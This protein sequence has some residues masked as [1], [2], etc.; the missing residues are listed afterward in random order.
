MKGTRICG[1]LFLILFG[2]WILPVGCSGGGGSTP[3]TTPTTVPTPTTVQ[4]AQQVQNPVA[5]FTSTGDNNGVIIEFP[6][7]T[8]PTA[9]LTGYMVFGI[10]TEGNNSSN[11]TTK[12]Y[13]DTSGL[14]YTNFPSTSTTNIPSFIDSGSNG[15]F[16]PDTIYQCSSASVAPGFYCTS[17]N[18]NGSG[19]ALTSLTATIT[20]KTNSSTVDFSVGDAVYMF[21]Y[22]GYK[23]YTVFNTLGGPFPGF[24]D[25]GLPFFYGNNVYTSIT[26]AGDGSYYAFSPYTSAPSGTN[27]QTITVNGGPTATLPSNPYIYANGAFTSVKVCVPGSV[28]GPSTCQTI[29]GVLVDTGSPGL[30]LLSS[31]L[32]LSLPAQQIGSGTLGECVQFADGSYIWGSV[33]TAD[34]Y[35]ANGNEIAHS[36]PIH[37]LDS[38]FSTLPSDC[39]TGVGPEEDDLDGL[40]A[41]GI[42]GIGSTRYDCPACASSVIPSTYYK[43]PSS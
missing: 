18:S 1:T 41:N 38:T 2:L 33:R 19:L 36:V 9:S 7:V 40:G 16:F 17:G 30:R 29:D 13:L 27:V 26:L 11:G 32:T 43:C 15:Y 37:V 4:L 3:T 12:F 20:D 10:D 22:N 5:L 35:L 23:D 28:P 6:S 31:V 34:V 21:T 42:L 14:I 25:W 24:F 39:P 8:G